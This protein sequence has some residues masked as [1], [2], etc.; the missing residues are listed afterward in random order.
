MQPRLTRGPQE[1]PGL[2]SRESSGG[3][4]ATS[5]PHNRP[6]P[7]RSGGRPYTGTAQELHTLL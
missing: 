1:E 3:R 2:R 4:E 7:W 5:A 6:G